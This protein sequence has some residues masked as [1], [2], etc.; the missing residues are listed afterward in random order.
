MVARRHAQMMEETRAKL[1]QAARKLS[2]PTATPSM[3]DLTA[4]AGPT[5]G[6]LDKKGLLQAVIDQI[7]CRCFPIS[8]RRFAA[9]RALTHARVWTWILKYRP[10]AH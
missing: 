2:R 9:K 3:D 5:R 4:K 7:G 8:R 10:I 6:A 1:I